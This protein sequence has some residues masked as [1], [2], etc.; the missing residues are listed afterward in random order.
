LKL[1]K[2]SNPKYKEPIKI[3]ARRRRLDTWFKARYGHFSTLGNWPDKTEL[4][5]PLSHWMYL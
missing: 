2:Q 5:K 3:G 1:Q 4:L